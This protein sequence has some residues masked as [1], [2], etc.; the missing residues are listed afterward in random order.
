[1]FL[2]ENLTKVRMLQGL[3]RKQ[4]A[5]M[6]GITE[7]GIWQ[8][9]TGHAS[10]KLGVVNKLK[11]IFHV[12]AKYFYERDFL[13]EYYKDFINYR[14]IAYRSSVINSVKKTQIE[15]VH[16]KELVALL[17]YLKQFIHLPE[18]RL[19]QLRNKAI[20]CLETNNQ[21]RKEAIR[22]IARFS[23]EFLGLNN[24]DNGNLL[25]LLEKNGAFIFEKSIGNKIDA[26][27]LWTDEEVPFI[28]LGN[29][30]KSSA[31]RNFDL[32]HELGHLLLHY[33]I[34]FSMLDQRTLREYE[35]EANLFAGEFLL[36]LEKFKEDFKQIIKPSHPD[37]YIPLKKKWSVSLQAL[38]YRANYLDFITYHQYRYFNI[39]VNKLK[40]K[41]IEPLDRE[42]PVRRPGKVKSIF[43]LLFEENYL[44]LDQLLEEMSVDI[45]YL[46]NLSGI[47]EEF[48]R[49][50]KRG[51]AKHFTIEDLKFV[52]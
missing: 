27:S 5:E 25:F 38:A 10:P 44:S 32:A 35:H 33:K 48:F 41:K 6:V 30:K 9:E 23:R 42:T 29:I 3:T 4:L 51:K 12:K 11:R 47:E 2:G 31:R 40:Y 21:D 19:K 18:N 24:T 14:Y 26:Y 36:P 52:E 1:M 7:Q 34:E 39:L 8:Y 49:A 45:K 46:T 13:E 20:D 15:S 43:Q 16:I 22:E 37:S 28:M 50:Y 17:N